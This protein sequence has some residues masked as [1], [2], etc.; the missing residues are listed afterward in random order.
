MPSTDSINKIISP[1]NNGEFR[2][3]GDFSERRK[4]KKSPNMSG[5]SLVQYYIEII[6]LTVPKEKQTGITQAFESSLISKRS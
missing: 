6:K 5:T 1:D 3:S 4:D 2:C